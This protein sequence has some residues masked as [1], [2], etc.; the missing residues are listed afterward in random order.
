M[1]KGKHKVPQVTDLTR[2]VYRRIYAGFVKGQRI[3]GLSLEAEAWFWRFM[4]AAD[5]FGNAEA[6]PAF[7]FANTVGRRKG[8][9]IDRVVEWFQECLRA[10]DDADAAVSPRV[11]R[12]GLL[13][14]YTIG[15]EV[16]YH[17]TDFKHLQPAG[18]NGKRVRRVPAS[19]WDEDENA[20]GIRVNPDLS[21]APIPTPIPTPTPIP[22]SDSDSADALVSDAPTPEQVRAQVEAEAESYARGWISAE[23]QTF[24]RGSSIRAFKNLILAKGKEQAVHEV[25][26]LMARDDVDDPFAYAAGIL[27]NE[28][29]ARA[30][31]QHRSAAP[32]TE[33]KTKR[34]VSF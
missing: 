16:F 25:Q 15:L 5:D 18:K 23:C 3:N 14:K 13:R 20:G 4:A 21:S 32:K 27:S 19:P 26:A 7:L 1:A 31:R 2:G 24:L 30:A 12:P 8:I 34:K 6:E 9:T 17:V 33:V 11:E 29:R 10:G 28:E 22:H